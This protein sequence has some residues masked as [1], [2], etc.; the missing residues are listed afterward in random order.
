MSLRRAFEVAKYV[1]SLLFADKYVFGEA[2]AKAP[3]VNFY[4]R[5]SQKMTQH[6]KGDEC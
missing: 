5:N 6:L 3:H 2:H 4:E 1:L